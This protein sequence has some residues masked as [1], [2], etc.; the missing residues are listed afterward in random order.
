MILGCFLGRILGVFFWGLGVFGTK[1]H[2]NTLFG[3]F[4]YDEN[5]ILLYSK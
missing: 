4:F 1:Q 5:I 3:G 2:F